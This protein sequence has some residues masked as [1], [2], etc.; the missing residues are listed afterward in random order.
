MNQRSMSADSEINLAATGQGW[1][2]QLRERVFSLLSGGATPGS[3]DRDTVPA[4]F[5]DWEK[6]MHDNLLAKMKGKAMQGFILPFEDRRAKT[7]L[8]AQINVPSS[9]DVSSTA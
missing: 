5:D 9:T 2:S 3:G 6:R 1:V 4:V 7:V 8:H